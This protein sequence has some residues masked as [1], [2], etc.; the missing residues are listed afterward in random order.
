MSEEF[1]G[2][3]PW[4]CAVVEHYQ[5]GVQRYLEGNQLQEDVHQLDHIGLHVFTNQN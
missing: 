3:L 1:E 4:V 2:E 5:P